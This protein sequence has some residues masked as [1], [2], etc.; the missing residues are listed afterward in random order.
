MG[1]AARKRR[2][3][4]SRRRAGR[5]H[6]EDLLQA[7]RILAF[8]PA[9]RAGSADA[10]V[11]R[12]HDR[13][14]Q[15]HSAHQQR[16]GRHRRR[17]QAGARR[18]ALPRPRMGPQ[19]LLRFPQAGL[20][21]HLALGGRPGRARRWSGRAHPPQGRLL[22]QAGVQ[23]HLAVEFH[24]DQSGTVSRNRRLERRKPGARHEDAGRGHRRRQGRPEAA[25]GRLFALR[26]RQEHR[27]HPRQGG[28][29]QRCRR[30]HPVRSGDRDGAQAAAADLPAMDQQV[31][32]P[33]S[34]PAEILHPLGDRTGPHRLRHLLDQSGR[35]PRR[36]GLGSLYP[37]G[38]AIR[39]RHD[40]EGHRRT[41]TSTP[42]AIASAARFWRQ[43]WR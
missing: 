15:R 27:H 18:Q 39:P 38:P 6:G 10:A 23:R 22:R 35:A 34:Q 17:G 7:Q 19:R 41:A 20:S 9:A 33:R 2:R 36:Q 3:A 28:W 31:L 4:R 8:R 24:P 11:L 13:L 26:D 21:R 5:R 25:P 40:R 43:P 16:R 14:G 1:R 29:P 30:D 37:R 32:H 12:L 42:S